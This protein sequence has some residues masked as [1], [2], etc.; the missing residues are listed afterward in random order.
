MVAEECDARMLKYLT[1]A[2]LKKI[3]ALYKPLYKTH[4]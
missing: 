2:G 4:E 3:I 1:E